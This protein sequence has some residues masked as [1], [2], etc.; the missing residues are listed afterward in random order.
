MKHI[1]IILIGLP[2][3]ALCQQK[4]AEVDT[5]KWTI[6]NGITK[7]SL[8][9]HIGDGLKPCAILNSNGEFEGR[10][11]IGITFLKK[12][13]SAWVITDTARAMRSFMKMAEAIMISYQH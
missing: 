11:S 12:P 13:D 6:G 1:L 10:D 7:Y 4:T 3:S 5:S 2:L 8:E 9:F